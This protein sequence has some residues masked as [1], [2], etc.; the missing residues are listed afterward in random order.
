[1]SQ[2]KSFYPHCTTVSFIKAGPKHLIILPQHE[3]ES[4]IRIWDK[5]TLKIVHGYKGHN[6]Q[7]S[8]TIFLNNHEHI[9]SCSHD[10]TVRVW[11]LKD[12]FEFDEC[13]NY[14]DNKYPVLAV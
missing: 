4:L 5:D 10:G 1:M 8:D 9:V 7:I 3:S 6:N 12:T 14:F 13:F 2:E 11:E